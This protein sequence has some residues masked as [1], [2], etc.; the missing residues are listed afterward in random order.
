MRHSVWY[1][2]LIV[3]WSIWFATALTEPVGVLACREHSP[4]AAATMVRAGDAAVQG[5][6]SHGAES[7][8]SGMEHHAH[9]APDAAIDVST[10]ATQ[11]VDAGHDA[12]APEPAGHSCCTCLGQCCT[13]AP[14]ELP[15]DFT[16]A[17]VELRPSSLVVAI[18][19]AIRAPQRQPHVLPFANGPPLIAL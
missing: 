10:L 14:A 16:I 13:M 19:H 4:V 17:T 7:R 11:Q 5:I 3:L 12:R 2:S 1:R 18:A 8:S 9:A 15:R 6:D